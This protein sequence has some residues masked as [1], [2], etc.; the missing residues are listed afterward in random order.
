MGSPHYPHLPTPPPYP[1]RLPRHKPRL[2]DITYNNRGYGTCQ[3]MS[4][5]VLKL[6]KTKAEL[7]QYLS[8]ALLSPAKSTLLWAINNNHLI[9]FP[10]LISS[11][12]SKHL[13]KSVVTSKGHLDQEFKNLRST[14][15]STPAAPPLP[16]LMKT[17]H[18]Y[19]NWT[20]Q[21][22]TTSCALS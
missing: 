4:N 18:P 7:A 19:K 6:D 2:I 10:G 15:T 20:M 17:L 12:I 5:G 3:P 14:K 13:P 11:L 21:K 22:Q 9:T 16:P 8:S 1:Q